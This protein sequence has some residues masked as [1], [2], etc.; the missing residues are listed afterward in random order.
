MNTSQVPEF[1]V[2]S[3]FRYALGR[4]TYVVEECCD[5]LC[6][7][8]SGLAEGV[9]NIIKK[10][11]EAA[12]DSDDWYSINHAIAV[13]PGISPLGMHCDRSQWERVRKLYK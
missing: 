3:A 9:Q 4:T 8:W 6:Y 7:N 10:E 2:I 11:L 1:M 12:F 13:Y 5:W